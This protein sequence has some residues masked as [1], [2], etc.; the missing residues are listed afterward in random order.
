MKRRDFF[1]RTAGTIAA[2]WATR[3]VSAA[4]V[5]PEPIVTFKAVIAGL[6][7][8][9]PIIS[10]LLTLENLQLACDGVQL[11]SGQPVGMLCGS[12]A[13]RR[14]Y[15][16]LCTRDQGDVNFIAL[17]DVPENELYA[18]ARDPAHGAALFMVA[19]EAQ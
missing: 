19:P 6:E 9:P 16:E 1:Q 5:A 13:L 17:R 11:R 8:E 4:I 15:I 18:V 2:L 12:H 10:G 3:H 7:V 14:R